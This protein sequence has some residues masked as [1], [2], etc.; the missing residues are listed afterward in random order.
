MNPPS[1]PVPGPNSPGLAK[2]RNN[3]IIPVRVEFVRPDRFLYCRDECGKQHTIHESDFTML[4]TIPSRFREYNWLA[5][6][7]FWAQA[8]AAYPK[9]LTITSQ[10]TSNETL[11]R[12]LRECRYAR[13][14]YNFAFHVANEAKW[15][16]LAER[17]VV[18]P[19][20]DGKVTIGPPQAAQTGLQ[21]VGFEAVVS[22]QNQVFIKW[23]AHP[24]VLESFCAL[25]HARAFDPK[26]QFVVF[27]LTPELIESL[28]SRYDVGFQPREDGKSWIVIF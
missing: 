12:K 9:T 18:T 26:P 1:C 14:R 22:G 8:L 20:D 25:I 23:D 2:L 5:L 21:T 19:T 7:P 13:D 3:G 6:E 4:P 17:L 24:Q 28:E 16:E 10:G 11:A 27:G 15:R